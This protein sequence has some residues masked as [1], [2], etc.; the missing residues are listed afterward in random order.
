MKKNQY[1]AFGRLSE[2]STEW[3]HWSILW[4]LKIIV[5]H[6]CLNMSFRSRQSAYFQQCCMNYAPDL[7]FP[8][9]EHWKL[10]TSDRCWDVSLHRKLSNS[11][12]LSMP[13]GP[14]IEEESSRTYWHWRCH[15]M[16]TGLPNAHWAKFRSAGEASL[17]SGPPANKDVTW[18]LNLERWT[19]TF[20][21][22]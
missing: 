12:S 16:L 11:S 10:L 18:V 14:T 9:I 4:L 17:D 3:M 15:Q 20:P 22:Y 7:T 13:T 21:C 1:Y 8:R 2:I 19:T 6:S 5:V